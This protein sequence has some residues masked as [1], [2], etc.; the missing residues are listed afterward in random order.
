VADSFQRQ[1]PYPL[2]SVSD[3][4]CDLES[5]TSLYHESFALMSNSGGAIFYPLICS[6]KLLSRIDP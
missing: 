1:G 4:V 6:L 2:K 5:P 3:A